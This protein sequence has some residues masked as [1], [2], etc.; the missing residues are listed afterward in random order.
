[1]TPMPPRARAVRLD[2]TASAA[3]L[4]LR[5][6]ALALLG[7][8][9]GA[10]LVRPA[11]A[12]SEAPLGEAQ[13]YQPI[14]STPIE[15]GQPLVVLDGMYAAN[16]RVG[17]L[18][19]EVRGAGGLAD[20]VTPVSVTVRVY[21]RRGEPL[22]EPVLVT[23]EHAGTA[24]LQLPGAATDEFGPASKD[25]DRR[26]PGTQLKVL[27]GEATFSL[28]APSQPEDVMLRLTAGAA[29]VS[30]SI[31][32][33]PDLREMIG[34]GLVEGV[35]RVSRGSETTVAPAGL[36]DGFEAE[37]KHWS[38]SFDGGRGQAALRGALFLKGKISGETLLT[39]TY[40]SDKDQRA[41]LLRDIQ[42][43]E[44]YP[45]YGD[46]SVKGFEAKSASRLYVRVDRG[47]TFALWGDFS[48]ADGF[49]QTAGSG[50]VAGTR[51]RQ[52]GAYSRSLTGARLHVER[53][54]GFANVYASRD[55]LKQLV[56]EV[57]ANGTSGPF[58]V[59]TTS[60]VELSEKVEILVRDR[61]NLNTIVSVTPLVRLNDYNF[62][63]FSGRILL[64]RPV[65]SLDSDG[66]P[67]SLRIT[68]EVDQGGAPFWLLGADGQYN[69][70]GSV[71]IGG[72]LVDDQN[73]NARFRLASVNTGVKLGERTTLVAELA[74]TEANLTSLNILTPAVT[75]DPSAPTTPGRAGRIVLDHQGE[76]WN[77]RLYANRAGS[78]FANG[79][80]GV[81]PGTQQAGAALAWRASEPLTLKSEAQLTQDL[82]TDARRTG[83]TVGADY[84]LNPALVVGGGLRRIDETG[85][86]SNATSGIGANP[87]AGSYF[88]SGLGGGFTGAGSTT[89][90]NLNNAGAS[91]SQAPGTV[92]DLA[93]TTAYVGA[94]YKVSERVGLQGQAEH[95]VAGDPGHRAE[96]GATYQLAER[97]RLYARAE[98]QTGLAS[99]Y[100]IDPAARS[101]VA[102]FGIDG[103][104]MRGGSVFSEYRLRDA[105]GNQASQLASGVRNAWA[106][107][108]GLLLSTG[109][110]RL[111][112]LSGSGQNATAATFGADYTASER[113]KASGRLEWRR[114]DSPAVSQL[115]TLPTQDSYLSTL[116][117]ARKLDRDWT[118]LTRNYYLAT[119]NHG[120][121]PNGWQDRFQIGAAYRP[122]DNNRFDLLS[123]Y[124]YK[125]EDNINA[126]DE[127]RRVHVGALQANVHPS[128]PWW[129]SAR[130]AAKQ[131]RERFPSTEGGVQD[132]Y[133][134]WLV[135]G[136]L[137]Y[138]VTERID[139][140][141]LASLMRGSAAA[142][143]GNATQQALGVEAGYLVQTNLWLSAGYNWTG[144]RDRDLSADY[145]SR[146]AYLRLRFKFDA[147]LFNGNN[148]AVN[149][150]LPR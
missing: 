128:R 104:Y 1:M 34:A 86:I 108:D 39:L 7:G 120:D 80:A 22:R 119:N 127:W 149:R 46:A 94:S 148:P 53:A 89:L 115:G 68:Y 26:V 54:D 141:L 40:D 125:V 137:I 147:D 50:L 143:D 43:E 51:L 3:P 27:D 24:R 33:V 109:L 48:T 77:G 70:N 84:Q 75:P 49:A 134:A 35:L 114:L 23:I 60:A 116:T 38:R 62:E 42:P 31:G 41:R 21:D 5:P 81:Q 36:D 6:L 132:S 100:G 126:T 63:P 44:F 90:I 56:E 146:G 73:P 144:F 85:R 12:Q 113:W 138:D 87:D 59:S 57:R 65:P 61:N 18:R 10:L 135:G 106:V 118:A 28:I 133:R 67:L 66:N 29:E 52:L 129:W 20:G 123:K 122:V 98:Q 19:V 101:T 17:Q 117:V 55:T 105:A 99:R 150:S 93:T 47:R 111:K 58:A 139:L 103:S 69:V 88:G 136:R 16:A 64:T 121:K 124:E 83:L 74:R 131:V 110:E 14:L 92:P 4:R 8:L 13:R 96:L 11:A 145:T 72:S 112:I 45:V 97:A 30:G 37:L 79:A 32:F 25:A 142:Q 9:A 95:S 130:L 15:R 102:A 107:Q 140:G 82:G 71:T 91:T 78:S 2:G 76:R